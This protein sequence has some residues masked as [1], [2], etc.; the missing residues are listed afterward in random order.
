MSKF[1]VPSKESVNPYVSGQVM[2][3][4]IRN[5]ARAYVTTG[6]SACR[7]FDG[8]SWNGLMTST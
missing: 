2:V 7:P 5:A 6:T 4:P 8:R 1:L 3:E